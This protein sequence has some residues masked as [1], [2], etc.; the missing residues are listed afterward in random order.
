M[1]SPEEPSQPIITRGGAMAVGLSRYFTGKPCVRGHVAERLISTRK[2]IICTA[3]K[4]ADYRAANAEMVRARKAAYAAANREKTRA[5]AKAYRATNAEK[6]RAYDA[7]RHADN[8][9]EE[10]IRKIAWRAANTEKARATD[11]AYR[12]AQRNRLEAARALNLAFGL[13]VPLKSMVA[14][15]ERLREAVAASEKRAKATKPVKAS[16]TGA[17]GFDTP[18]PIRTVSAIIAEDGVKPAEAK[19]IQ[20]AE[21]I[22]R[23][24]WKPPR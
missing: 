20:D 9:E 1:K 7:A 24:E 15:L 5:R 8:R 14:T 22:A 4:N 10:R 21:I 3:A 17:V 18:P 12:D 23:A 13:L 11:A 2:C 6:L 16:P 19:R